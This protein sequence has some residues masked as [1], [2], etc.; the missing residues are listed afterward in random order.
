[1]F[2]VTA[3]MALSCSNAKHGPPATHAES[4]ASVT[5]PTLNDS[6]VVLTPDGDCVGTNQ[7]PECP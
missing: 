5:G 2:W 1:M 3:G 7:F 6:G 4:G